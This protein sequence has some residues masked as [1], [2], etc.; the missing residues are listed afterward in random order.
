[1]SVFVILKERRLLMIPMTSSILWTQIRIIYPLNPI[2]VSSTTSGKS[3]NRPLLLLSFQ[4]GCWRQKPRRV[5]EPLHSHFKE[6]HGVSPDFFVGAL[7]EA[8]DASLLGDSMEDVR[9]ALFYD[10]QW[11]LSVVLATPSVGLSWPRTKCVDFAFLFGDLLPLD[12][13][14]ISTR[15]LSC[16]AVGRH[17]KSEHRQVNYEN[18]QCA[19]SCA[20]I[21]QIEEMVVWDVFWLAASEP[22]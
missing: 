21:C 15:E 5:I 8:V 10:D 6:K 11:R 19:L 9:L 16:A 20:C 12:T 17:F 2:P 1:M 18:R 7:E 4:S 14:W 3:E 13:D 22:S